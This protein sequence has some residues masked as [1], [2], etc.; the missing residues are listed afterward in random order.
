MNYNSPLEDINVTVC[1]KKTDNSEVK[2]VMNLT[3]NYEVIKKHFGRSE[4]NCRF[5]IYKR[6]LKESFSFLNIIERA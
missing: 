2:I 3:K 4:N 6:G 5:I 1:E